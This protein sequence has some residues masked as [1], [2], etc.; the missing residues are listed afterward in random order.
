MELA[1]LAC[2]ELGFTQGIPDYGISGGLENVLRIKTCPSN[3]SDLEECD[4]DSV[5][6]QAENVSLLCQDERK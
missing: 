6:D 4:I 1:K 3:A 2:K 5:N